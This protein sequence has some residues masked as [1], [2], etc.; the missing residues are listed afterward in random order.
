MS[1]RRGERRTLVPPGLRVPFRLGMRYLPWKPY[2]MRRCHLPAAN[3]VVNKERCLTRKHRFLQKSTPAAANA[4]CAPKTA[5][6]L[7]NNVFPPC[8][9]LPCGK[10]VCLP[11]TPLSIRQRRLPPTG[12]AARKERKLPR[13][14]RLSPKH[15]C[16][17]NLR[18]APKLRSRPEYRSH[19]EI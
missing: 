17:Q 8:T 13:K 2:T 18:C 9:P 4:D 19:V 1:G 6:P 15:L 14:R 5:F 3:G 7:G 11:S 16:R 12:S 10:A